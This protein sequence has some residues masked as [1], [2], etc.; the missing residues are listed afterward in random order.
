MRTA[1]KRSLAGIAAGALAFA[2]LAFVAAP[3]AQ[4][5]QTVAAIC[6][7]TGTSGSTGGSNNDPT[8]I[9]PNC[10][11]A[12]GLGVRVNFAATFVTDAAQPTVVELSVAGDSVFV[13]DDT[14]VRAG[15]T[16]SA[17]RTQVIGPRASVLSANVVMTVPTQGVRTVT[18]RTGS[19]VAEQNLTDQGTLTVTGTG[20]SS[21]IVV[22]QGYKVVA[23]DDTPMTNA[24]P[25]GL[26][27]L[28][29]AN[30]APLNL[31]GASVGV[32]TQPVGAGTVTAA[33]TGTSTL[34]K[35]GDC[36]AD[37]LL[38]SSLDGQQTAIAGIVTPACAT[39]LAASADDTNF[40]LWVMW[41]SPA[42]A[43][44]PTVGSYTTSFNLTLAGAVY[45]VS[46][47]YVVSTSRAAATT[48]VSF[49]KETYQ[50]GE[51]VVVTTSFANVNGLPVADGY[52]KDDSAIRAFDA[53]T[54]L[55]NAP[56]TN[57]ATGQPTTPRAAFTNGAAGT[58]GGVATGAFLAPDA[59]MDTFRYTLG[60]GA[61]SATSFVLGSIANTT[62]SDTARIGNPVP[63]AQE[64]IMIEGTR[65][66]GDDANRVY[67]EG[68]TV[69]LVGKTV[70]PYF[71]FPGE[72]GFTAG[73][74]ARTV[75]AQGNF[76]W[77]RKTGKKIAVQFRAGDGVVSNTIIIEAK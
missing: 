77:Q 27:H 72:T 60:L 15:V 14:A 24:V 33:T 73:T 13:A 47:N 22:S 58:Y 20:T 66:V 69:N 67:V 61:T 56:I 37:G 51:R 55:A 2:G 10:S 4:A 43:P 59:A 40:G 41:Q 64:S 38:R 39:T 5:A 8:T 74:G 75:D 12:A 34:Y 54:T 49:D 3:S 19:T 18:V 25:I 57:P 1:G 31:A 50:P 52:G 76:S 17:D 11:I 16:V 29:D 28:L 36:D 26:V 68:T 48:G 35:G 71:R 30:G 70:T 65:G 21:Q 53:S 63:P 6:T 46:V 42:S 23:G 45:P 44:A 9:V 7:G 62:S 32:I